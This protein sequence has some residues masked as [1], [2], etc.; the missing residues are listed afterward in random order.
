MKT[1]PIIL[2]LA[3]IASASVSAQSTPQMK[4]SPEHTCMMETTASDWKTIGLDA[5]QLAK[6][7]DIQSMC[8]KECASVKADKTGTV[9][10]DHQAAMAKHTADVKSTLSPEQYDKW[11]AWC[12]QRSTKADQEPMKK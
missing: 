4:S 3:L 1:S 12:S 6:V 10:L 11:V 9:D 2:S 8:K 5:D 7:Q